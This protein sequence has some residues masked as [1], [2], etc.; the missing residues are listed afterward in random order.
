MLIVLCDIPIINSF[1]SLLVSHG[2]MLGH[3]VR[4]V[5]FTFAPVEF[6]LLLGFSIL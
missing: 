2:V 3:V 5:A 4:S 6:E 1:H